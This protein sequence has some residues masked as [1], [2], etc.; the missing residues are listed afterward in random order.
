MTLFQSNGSLDQWVFGPMGFRTN[1]F[2][3]KWTF[4]P[5]TLFGPVGRRTND[6]LFWTSGLSNQLHIFLDQWFFEPIR[7]SDQWVVGPA[8]GFS[9][10][11]RRTNA[12]GPIATVGPM[13]F[14]TNGS[15]D[16]WSVG[17][18]TQYSTQRMG[19]L[20]TMRGKGVVG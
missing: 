2:S 19:R 5:M 13:G 1:V 17:S 7:L 14:R 4:G 16:Q 6:T 20:L 9:D 15:A 12:V 8:D 11:C 3:D 18:S 10:Q